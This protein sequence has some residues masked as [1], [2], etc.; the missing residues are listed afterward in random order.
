[1]LARWH[2]DVDN[3]HCEP[4]HEY[5]ERQHG[6]NTTDG[7]IVRGIVLVGQTNRLPKPIELLQE[8]VV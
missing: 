7:R 5:A 1:M 6:E 2:I 4:R 8:F 3:L